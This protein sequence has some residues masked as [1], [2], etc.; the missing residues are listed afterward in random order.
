MSAPTLFPPN[1]RERM[2]AFNRVMSAVTFELLDDFPPA[3]SLA[4]TKLA[5]QRGIEFLDRRLGR[6]VWLSRIDLNTL[7]VASPFACVVAQ[8]TGTFY[9]SGLGLLL[10]P[11]E[12]VGDF[13]Y[14]H[15]FVATDPVSYRLLTEE[16]IIRVNELRAAASPRVKVLA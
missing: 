2:Q 10:R 8:V 1:L 11:N 6:D 4:E 9:G 7:N 12:H 16:W 3:R 5:V 15:G 14:N 13:T